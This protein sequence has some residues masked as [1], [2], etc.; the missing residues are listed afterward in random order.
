MDIENYSIATQVWTLRHFGRVG[1]RTFRTLMIHFG[2]LENIF[3]AE[4]EDLLEINGLGEKRS[5]RICDCHETLDDAEEFINTMREREIK[6]CT[7]FDDDYPQLFNEL[8]DPPPIFFTR[9]SLPEKDEKT[10]GIVGSHK[11]TIEG[12]GYAVDLAGLLAK[13]SVSIVSGLARG[14]DASAHIGC[15]RAGGKSYAI[16]GSGFDNIY[17]EEN[18][19]LSIEM[20]EKGGL[21]S[22]Y[23]PDTKNS[24]GLN[25]SRNRLIVGLSNAV[26][27]GEIFGDSSGTL[28]S[29]KCCVELGKLMFILIDGCERE[30]KDNKGV[31][32]VLEM[33]A[34]PITLENAVEIITKSLV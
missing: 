21:I 6:C 13:K 5:K 27:I 32:K 25:M 24:P 9:G 34:I 33:G 2:N 29:A 10:V 19:P 11:A 3:R 1:P 28:D 4:M 26:I 23:S 30:G 22:E 14:I 31:E 16:L 18:I 8:N 20:V 15:I 12:I 17:P 7:Q